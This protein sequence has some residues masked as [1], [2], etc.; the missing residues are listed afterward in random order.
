MRA[1]VDDRLAHGR[2]LVVSQTLFDRVVLALQLRDAR[3]QLVLETLHIGFALRLFLVK[4]FLLL[5]L[6]ASDLLLQAFLNALQIFGFGLVNG[7]ERFT[8]RVFVN[9]DDHKLREV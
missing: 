8:A 3:V 1:G 4:L 2:A 6:G 9:G 7:L 5:L